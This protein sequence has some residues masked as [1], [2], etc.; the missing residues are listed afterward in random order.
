MRIFYSALCA[1]LIVPWGSLVQ[2]QSSKDKKSYPDD[3]YVKEIQKITQQKSVKDAFAAIDNFEP[4][5]KKEHIFLTEIPAPPFKESA[6][7]NQ[8]KQMLQEAGAD[9]VWIDSLGNVLALRKGKKSTRTIALDAHLDTVFPEET[10]V[11]V[12]MKGDT[13]YAPGVGDDTRGLSSVLT[14]LKAMEKASL[15]TNNDVLFIGSL[16]E[17]G[18]GDL[19]GVKYIFQKNNP[20]IDTWISVDGD[21]IGG[22]TNGALGSVRY[23]VTVKGPGGHSWAA[24]GLAN[25]HHALGKAI[26]YF[27]EEAT[28][29]TSSPGAKTSFNVGRVGGGT[30]INA[31][32]FESWMEV[33]MRSESGD[34]L[35][36]IDAIFNSSVNRAIDDYNK[37]V[38]KGR[39]LSVDIEQIGY[40]PSGVTNASTSLIQRTVA[41]AKYFG[42]NPTLNIVSTNSNI[43]ISKGIPAV[44][45]GPGG[46][47][48]NAHA[49]NEWYLNEKGADG[50]KFILLV[51]LTEA[52]VA[53]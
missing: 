4:E 44:T 15:E 52:G 38:K 17:E 47:S 27:N 7:A 8:F 39:L 24:F 42:A 12:K 16:G 28:R 1:F 34:R 23:K 49:L 11:K 9:N 14:V 35:K 45:I 37:T 50:I 51:L 6:R 48:D 31:I 18:L 32:P 41:A 5:T 40:R 53:K 13:L 30:S 21:E 10:D 20:K 22:V 26:D 43:P 29:Y 36:E 25:P 2:A 19:R 46:K 3:I 33:D